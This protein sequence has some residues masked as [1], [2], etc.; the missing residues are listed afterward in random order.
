MVR[1]IKINI[2]YLR[3]NSSLIYPLYAGNGERIVSE[4]VTLTENLLRDI[5]NRY[6]IHVYGRDSI[7]SS[8]VPGYRMNIALNKARDI[9]NEIISSGRFSHTNFRLAEKLAEEI[10]SDLNSSEIEAVSLLKDLRSFD[11][12]LYMHS[13]NV[14]VLA[15]IF[16]RLMGYSPDDVK[17]FT[18]GGYLID[19]GHMLLDK[20]LNGNTSRFSISEIQKV[21]RHPQLGYELLKNIRGVNTLVLQAVLFHHERFNNEGYFQM[22][23]DNLPSAPKIIAVCDIFDAVTSR[24][25]YRDA[26]SVSSAL[27]ILLNSVNVHLDY[28]T[29][30]HF[31][32]K[33]GPLLNN[34]QSFYAVDD[35]CEL[36]TFE[37]ALIREIPSSDILKPRV[38][39]FCRFEKKGSSLGVRFYDRPVDIDL[40]N[41]PEERYISKILDNRNQ[42]ESIRRKLDEKGLAAE[43]S[44]RFIS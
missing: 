9:M 13:V 7:D 3:P 37:L 38:R 26:Q 5:R 39:I 14:G 19:I 1:D 11:Q 22:P 42:V 32:N 18:L 35:I 4:R 24:R 20:Q 23:Y 44:G 41:D 28:E 17:N 33:L 8:I 36:N 10:V 29:V 2:D 15:G 16:S 6:G 25:S 12:Y 34:S 30:S 21:K 31:V 27:K 43:R 40:R